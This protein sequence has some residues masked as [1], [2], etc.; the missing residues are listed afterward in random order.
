MPPAARVSDLHTCP[1]F[2]GPIPHVGGPI[3]IGQSNVMI[4]GMQAARM[5]DISL[6]ASPAT[7]YVQPDQIAI[8]STSVTIGYQPAARMGDATSHGGV[9][10][11]GVPTV[12]IGG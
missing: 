11:T 1:A 9:I 6:C 10:S 2:T 12:L 4:V 7:P 5:G 8:G 3:I